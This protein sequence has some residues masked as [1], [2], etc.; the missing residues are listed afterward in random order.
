MTDLSHSL[1]PSLPPSLGIYN[2]TNPGAISHN[3]ILALYKK[4][5]DPSYTWE[6][7]AVRPSF[8]PSLPSSPALSPTPKFWPCTRSTSTFPTLGRT[9][10]YVLLS[11]PPSLPLCLLIP[12]FPP[13]PSITLNLLDSVDALWCYA[14]TFLRSFSLP[15][16]H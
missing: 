10:R 12:S 5:V 6:K 3:Q 4:H 14:H 16:P 13:T 15:F 11:L 1:P 8:R 7:L 9:S 2:F